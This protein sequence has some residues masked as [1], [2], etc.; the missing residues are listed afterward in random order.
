MMSLIIRKAKLE[1]KDEIFSLVKDFAT[2]FKAEKDLFNESMNNLLESDSALVLVAEVDDRIIGYCLGFVH[3]TFYANGRVAWIEEIMVDENF[4][5]KKVGEM[6]TN[7]FEEWA[8]S[9][10]S[11][12]VALATRRAEAFYTSIGYEESA[13]YFRKLL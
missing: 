6:L 2:S 1:D 4:R 13:K 9:K 7:S 11:R 10:N 3:Y 12:L 5:R 8:H